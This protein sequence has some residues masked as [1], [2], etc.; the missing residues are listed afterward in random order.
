ML[1]HAIQA[2]ILM[3]WEDIL[4]LFRHIYS[5]EHGRKTMKTRKEIQEY[6]NKS[7]EEAFMDKIENNDIVVGI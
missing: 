1:V 5:K 7:L 4:N 3:S 2:R 6:P